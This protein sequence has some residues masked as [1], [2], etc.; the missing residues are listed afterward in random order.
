M[1]SS[2]ERSPSHKSSFGV[3]IPEGIHRLP[4]WGDISPFSPVKLPAGCCL[5]GPVGEVGR[6]EELAFVFHETSPKNQGDRIIF[7]EVTV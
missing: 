4:L 7:V 6:G 1:E 5:R 2:V 3:V